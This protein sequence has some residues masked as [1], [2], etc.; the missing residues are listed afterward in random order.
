MYRIIIVYSS[1]EYLYEIITRALRPLKPINDQTSF[2]VPAGER[3]GPLDADSV[4]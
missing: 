2:I 3:A 1:N 4:D